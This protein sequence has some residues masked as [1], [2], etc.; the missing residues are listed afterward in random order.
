M[1]DTATA[2]VSADG[3]VTQG[4]E[5]DSLGN[6]TQ[7]QEQEVKAER[8]DFVKDKY[9]KEGRSEQDAAYEQAKAYLEAEKRLGGFTGAPDAYELVVSEDMQAAGVDIDADD[10]TI[11]SMMEFAKK[12]NMSQ[13]SFNEF[14]NEI[15][16][17]EIAKEEAAKVAA[18]EAI[19][20][21]G[22]DGQKRI[23][24]IN[25]VLKSKLDDASYQGLIGS[26]NSID[27]IKGIEALIGLTRNAPVNPSSVSAAPSITAAEVKAMQFAL[28]EFGQR[29]IQSDPAFKAEFERKAALLYGTEPYKQIIG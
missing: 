13:E 24:N 7:T 14:I 15:A 16:K 29:K 17:N 1:T 26:I 12:T 4:Q 2:P 28:D 23:D 11:K 21:L 20:S 27:A 18:Q 9:R 8:F 5:I 25:A 10:I 22:T 19:K 3:E 6:V